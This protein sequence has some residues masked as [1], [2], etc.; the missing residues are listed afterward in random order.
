MILTGKAKL[1]GVIGWPVSHSKS[2]RLHGFWLDKYGIDGAYL[3]LPVEPDAFET[4]VLGL[5]ASGFR[6]CNVTIPHKEAALLLADHKTARAEKIGASNTLVFKEDGTILA[7]NTDGYG[8][9]ENLFQYAPD[10]QAETGPA[11]VLGAGG[12]ARG[13][14]VGLLEAGVPEIRLT[15]RTRAR[16]EQLADS[17][18]GAITVVDWP[19][20]HQALAGA[21]LLV[22]TTTL[23]MQ[24]QAPLEIDL[25]DL[26]PTALVSDIVY[27]PLVTPLLADAKKRGCQTVDGIGMLLHQARPG[28]KAWF[29]SDPDVD[30]ALRD[31]VLAE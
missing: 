20:R 29:G 3:P 25:D 15:N 2:P 18:E 14:V 17:L 4:A 27:A 16:A 24:G 12:A 9:M 8:F 19:A 1:A 11:V 5:K 10:W 26:A 30:Q 28:F 13:V 22:N 21:H 7:D 23:G 31:F 6:G